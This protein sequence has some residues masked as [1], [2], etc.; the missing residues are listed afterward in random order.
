MFKHKES[1]EKKESFLKELVDE[2]DEELTEPIIELDGKEEFPIIPI[3][4]EEI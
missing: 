4:K 1:K 3:T 2:V